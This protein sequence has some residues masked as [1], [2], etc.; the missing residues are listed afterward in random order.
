[1]SH[2]IGNLTQNVK[3]E[4][5]NMKSK[6]GN[7]NQNLKDLASGGLFGQIEQMIAETQRLEELNSK[8][9][10][11]YFLLCTELDRRSLQLEEYAN[12]VHNLEETL[13]RKESEFSR[14]ISRIREEEVLKMKRTL[15]TEIENLKNASG[16][17]KNR[18]ERR[19]Q[20][21]QNELSRKDLEV[22]EYKKRSF[23]YEQT[24]S[25]LKTELAGL[26]SKF[27][28]SQD[29]YH[30]EINRMKNEHSQLVINIENKYKTEI[31]NLKRNMADENAR[32]VEKQKSLLSDYFSQQLTTK[33][34]E[35]RSL[36][37][38]LEQFK[39]RSAQLEREN[40]GLNAQ[41]DQ[42]TRELAELKEQ[43]ISLKR[44][45]EEHIIKI[46]E[47]HRL[48]IQNAIN[49]REKEM[50][51]KLESEVIRLEKEL[52]EKKTTILNLEQKIMY[53]EK[54]NQRN[55]SRLND[56]TIERD[57]LKSKLNDF[58]KRNN[59][60]MRIIEET[61]T[62]Q[63][64]EKQSEI[65]HL[66]AQLRD[67]NENYSTQLEQEKARANA[68]AVENNNLKLE[69]VKLKELSDQRNR[70]IDEWRVKYKSY[71]T[72]EE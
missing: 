39:T 34:G 28:Q 60:E 19:I 71:I 2:D 50:K 10:I 30:S 37:S 65:D 69:I 42:R 57:E 18:L 22:G 62:V 33:D 56:M 16:N 15:E 40:Q 29:G 23:A 67:F 27:D 43:L 13:A 44:T 48:Q 14:E 8:Y 4:T 3:G 11:R 51:E 25:S 32:E 38:S 61:L 21:L 6:I 64:E 45:H 31:D 41:L 66:M 55:A 58:E 35:I 63:I 26:N 53:M 72:A 68:L 70:E 49:E 1:M 59:E 7:L 17:E 54:E 20:D 5:E 46:T 12:H 52:K 47:T 9:E 36:S 24:I